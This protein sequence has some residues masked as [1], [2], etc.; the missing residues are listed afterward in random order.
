M[1]HKRIIEKD[2]AAEVPASEAGASAAQDMYLAKF[3]SCQVVAEV[4]DDT[5][6]AFLSPA[7][8]TLTDQDVTYDA[9]EP[10]DAGNDITITLVDPSANDEPLAIQV[11]DTDIVV[12]L[13]TDSGGLI[14]TDA[15]ALVLALND[16][17]SVQAL[18]VA[19]GTGNTPLTAL[20]ETPLAGGEDGDVDINES[21]IVA[22]DLVQGA[23]VQLSTD[24]TLPAPLLAATDYFVITN[25]LPA[26]LIRLANTA[27]DAEA[28]L[29]IELNDAGSDGAE[30]EITPET[31]SGC[32]VVLQKSNDGVNYEDLDTPVAIS[33]SGS[34][35]LAI[36]QANFKYLKFVKALSAGTVAM[37]ANLLVI[38]DA[39]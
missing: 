1:S 14:V 6:I 2:A 13:E 20:T 38:G 5:P 37:K 8:A 3:G 34:V 22:A 29:Y 36:E 10:G 28:G 31:A 23:K 4:Q 15:D 26:G 18:I 35:N 32:T 17:P 11:T 9:I 30:N 24:G 39:I 21:T 19:S 7:T 16:D 12:T 33:A 27:E 25:G